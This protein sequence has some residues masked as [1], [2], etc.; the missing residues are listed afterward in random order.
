MSV[1]KMRSYTHFERLEVTRASSVDEIKTSFRRFALYYH[2][3]KNVKNENA[4]E[5]F[6]MITEAR[7][8]LLD[9]SER[10]RYVEELR[11]RR[12]VNPFASTGASRGGFGSANLESRAAEILRDVLSAR[13]THIWGTRNA[14]A[15][16]E[17]VIH[18]SLTL[19]QMD[20][21]CKFTQTYQ[22]LVHRAVEGATLPRTETTTVVVPPGAVDGERIVIPSMGD[23]YFGSPPG[24]LVF[25]VRK[26]PH[27]TFVRSI[28]ANLVMERKITPL[29]M[30]TGTTLKFKTVYGDEHVMK[31]EAPLKNGQMVVI[32]GV[33]LRLRELA[34]GEPDDE[35]GT[36]SVKLVLD[37]AAPPPTAEQLRVA[38]MVAVS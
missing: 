28:G 1:E 35:R 27:E 34:R 33:G 37:N 19:E 16:T 12:V 30:I 5:L 18:V 29:E 20:K 7:D 17:R 3:D 38:S 31:L 15:P 13:G 11:T 2:P 14:Q 26:L 23:H 21:G 4:K 6:N 10:Q 24:D 36:V 32:S 8:V 9:P 25:C 22:R